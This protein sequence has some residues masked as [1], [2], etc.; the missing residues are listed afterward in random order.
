MI[1]PRC[2]KEEKEATKGTETSG[3]TQV[4]EAWGA[5]PETMLVDQFSS[6]LRSLLGVRCR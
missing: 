1:E 2:S 6:R 3:G 4:Q 5:G